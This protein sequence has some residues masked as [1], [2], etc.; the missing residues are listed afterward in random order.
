MTLER[1]KFLDFRPED[2]LPHDL[3]YIF[4]SGVALDIKS[5]EENMY[6]AYC[7]RPSGVTRPAPEKRKV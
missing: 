7:T 2:L 1:I 5:R 3:S 6:M 4:H